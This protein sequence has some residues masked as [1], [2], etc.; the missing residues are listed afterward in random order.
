MVQLNTLV[1]ILLGVVGSTFATTA[2]DWA[3]GADA[4]KICP[5]GTCCSADN[6]W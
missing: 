4:G 1:I 2:A 3:C 5:K 6:Y